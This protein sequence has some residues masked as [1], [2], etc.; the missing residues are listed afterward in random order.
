MYYSVIYESRLSGGE[1]NN[2][3]DLFHFIS[4]NY[5]QKSSIVRGRSI[6]FLS[7]GSIGKNDV[8]SKSQLFRNPESPLRGTSARM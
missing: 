2:F 4:I 1:T 8:R 6:G 5:S 3:G 7:I